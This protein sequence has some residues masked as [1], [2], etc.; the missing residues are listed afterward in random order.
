VGAV[1]EIVIV[2]S[3]MIPFPSATMYGID[4]ATPTKFGSGLKVTSPEV[5]LRV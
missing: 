1:I 4:V 5:T 3:T 2:E